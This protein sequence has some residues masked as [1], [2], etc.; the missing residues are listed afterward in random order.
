VGVIAFISVIAKNKV[1]ILG[2]FLLLEGIAGR[3]INIGFIQLDAV[4]ID[5]FL[6]D[7]YRIV[8]QCDNALDKIS[9]LVIGRLE[10]NDIASLRL[11]EAIAYLANDQSLTIVKAGLHADTNHDNGIDGSPEQEE[12]AQG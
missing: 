5:G 12:N 11:M 8:G 3:V 10:D 6:F 4:N 9:L 1:A 2:N 7:L